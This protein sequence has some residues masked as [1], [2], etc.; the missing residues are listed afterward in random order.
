MKESTKRIIAEKELVKVKE[1]LRQVELRHGSNKGS[2]SRHIE[3]MNEKTLFGFK[4]CNKCLKTLL[5]DKFYSHPFTV[6]KRAG[7]CKECRKSKYNIRANESE[8]PV[9]LVE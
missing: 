7:T 3:A 5:L 6:D 2:F 9:E 1:Q 8:K 4:K